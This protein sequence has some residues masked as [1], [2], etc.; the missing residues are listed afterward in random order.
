[1]VR[2]FFILQKVK[3][4]TIYIQNVQTFYQDSSKIVRILCGYFYPKKYKKVLDNISTMMYYIIVKRI[5]ELTQRK[6]VFIMFKVIETV[7]SNG[8]YIK[9]EVYSTNHEAKAISKFNEIRNAFEETAH[10]FK[11]GMDM[12]FSADDNYINT[13]RF[14]IFNKKHTF[15]LNLSVVLIID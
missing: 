15:R 4:L 2:S 10:N 7:Q 5:K 6:G 8:K 12:D 13:S 14:F 1:M 3:C 9:K 11:N